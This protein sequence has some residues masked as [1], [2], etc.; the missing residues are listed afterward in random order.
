MSTISELVKKNAPA[1]VL[2]SFGKS[3]IERR[4]GFPAG[5]YTS[6][7]PVLYMLMGV[8]LTV[9]F[10][11]VLALWPDCMIARMFTQRGPTPYA[12]ALFSALACMQLLVKHRK[13]ALQKKALSLRLLPTDDP[14][15]ILTPASSEHILQNLYESI[16]DPDAFL[17][18]RRIRVALGNLRNMGRIGD[19]DEV[20]KTQA[21]NDE[22]Q[23]DSSYALL[24]GLIWAIPVLGFIGTVLG[25]SVALGGFGSVLS[26]AN[27]MSQLRG[28]L[29]NVTGGLSTAFETTLEGLVA[30]L[31]IQMLMIGMRRREDQFL[32]QCKDYCQKNLVGRLRLMASDGT[33]P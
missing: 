19:V 29:Q 10:Y 28:A 25:L 26:A 20:L 2:L 23:V 9:A 21:E 31:T 18:T 7:G 5:R 3:D 33:Q 4:I 17:L 1:D 12:I 32:D 22:G 6:A 27:D 8:I 24:R 30:A 13:L 15:F 14:G 16:D 11:G